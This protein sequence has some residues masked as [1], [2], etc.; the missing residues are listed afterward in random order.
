MRS[1][2]GGMPIPLTHHN[3]MLE[4]PEEDTR[5]RVRRP[6][7]TLK[8]VL[9]SQDSFQQGLKSFSNYGHTRAPNQFE[10]HSGNWRRSC[11]PSDKY[12]DTILEYI[13]SFP[14]CP[15]IVISTSPPY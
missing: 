12:Q 1:K 9:S 4:D 6:V 15:L 13:Q 11:T 3:G 10:F 2:L 7:V 8:I 14:I 5:G